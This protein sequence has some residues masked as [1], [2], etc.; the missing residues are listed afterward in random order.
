M[1]HQSGHSAIAV[2]EW[3][4]PEQSMVGGGRGND[5]INWPQP[6]ID[7]LESLHEARHGA[8]ADRDMPTDR[9]IGCPEFTRV[10]LDP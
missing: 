4:D 10:N 9:H 5:G 8:R 3:M 7:F 6:C 2:C 1:R